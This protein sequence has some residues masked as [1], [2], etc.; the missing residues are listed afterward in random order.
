MHAG[1][2]S[3]RAEDEENISRLAHVQEQ[4]IEEGIEMDWRLDAVLVGED[5]GY[6][7]AEP[8]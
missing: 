1:R 3:K 8:E 7:I 6:R 4:D 5:N 2:S